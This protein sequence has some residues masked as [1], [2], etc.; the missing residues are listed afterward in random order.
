MESLMLKIL[1]TKEKIFKSKSDLLF[2]RNSG[3]LN[4]IMVNKASMTIFVLDKKKAQ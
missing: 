3:P 1:I 2:H 4:V